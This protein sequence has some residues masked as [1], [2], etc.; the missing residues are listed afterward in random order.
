MIGLDATTLIAFEIREH[1]QHAAVRSGV[2]QCLAAGERFGLLDQTLWEFLHI[3]TDARRFQNPLTMEDAI[4][5]AERWANA[6]EVERV[7]TSAESRE[8]TLK[9][10]RDFALGRKRILDTSL[11]AA[12][13]VSGISR[14]ATANKA[15]FECFGEFTFEPWALVS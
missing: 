6:R 14:I 10:M 7:F 1:P 13:Y 5:R 4:Q 15:D 9:W 3:V 11:A 2:R 8:W 12:F